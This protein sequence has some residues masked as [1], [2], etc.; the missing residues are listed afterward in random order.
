ML[1]LTL[2]AG[3]LRLSTLGRQSY[4]YDEA[5]RPRATGD[6]VDSPTSWRSS[7]NVAGSLPV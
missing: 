4:W 2:V 5:V 6:H 3:A 7:V 1:I